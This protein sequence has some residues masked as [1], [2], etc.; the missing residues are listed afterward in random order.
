MGSSET[1][2]SRSDRVV[3]GLK[4]YRLWVISYRFY[5]LSFTLEATVRA[6][7]LSLIQ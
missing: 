3:L 6:W 4:G 7:V 1:R 2:R 5:V